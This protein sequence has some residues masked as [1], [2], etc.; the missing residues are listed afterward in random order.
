MFAITGKLRYENGRIVG[1]LRL[2][3]ELSESVNNIPISNYYTKFLIKVRQKT[4]NPT[5]FSNNYYTFISLLKFL[6]RNEFDKLPS[7]SQPFITI[8]TSFF[9]DPSQF[10]SSK[11]LAA[12]S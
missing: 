2:L 4:A 5:L 11:M 12:F 7:L 8:L 6:E 3:N 10:S 1:I 9:I